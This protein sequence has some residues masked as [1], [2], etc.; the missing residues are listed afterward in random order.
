[1]TAPSWPSGG[2][3]VRIVYWICWRI[4][5]IGHLSVLQENTRLDGNQYRSIGQWTAGGLHLGH[6][7]LQ[8]G[9]ASPVW[10]SALN[11]LYSKDDCPVYSSGKLV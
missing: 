8:L 4:L 5:K 7:L 6:T 3:F 9:R 1:M 11:L 10:L 2:S